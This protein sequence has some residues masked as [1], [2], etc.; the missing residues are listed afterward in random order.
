LDADALVD[1]PFMGP[2][3]QGGLAAATG[4]LT[5]SR[6]GIG[7][8]GKVEILGLEPPLVFAPNRITGAN[9]ATL[10]L[11]QSA[12]A[13]ALTGAKLG[14]VELGD[15]GRLIVEPRGPDWLIAGGA[16][17]DEALTG[18]ALSPAD[19]FG[20]A[21]AYAARCDRLPDADPLLRSL[22]VFGVHAALS[23]ARRYPDG[24]FAGV[25]AG[26]VYSNP[27]RSYYRD[28]YWTLQLV[29]QL[30]PDLAAAEIE[31]LASRIGPDGEAPSAVILEGRHADEFEHRRLE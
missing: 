17:H 16:H 13:L 9:G 18:L 27:P 15:A 20:E 4:E 1:A 14:R 22:V 28:G 25:S 5:L 30:A 23:S 26:L 3:L 31:L 12:P 8:I 24:A 7:E 2:A 21:E 11:A 29:I 19:V 10:A 6:W